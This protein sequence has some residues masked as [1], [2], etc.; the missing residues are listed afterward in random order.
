MSDYIKKRARQAKAPIFKE[1]YQQKIRNNNHIVYGLAH[2]TIYHRIYKK[3]EQWPDTNKTIREFNEWGQPLVIDLTFVKN[4]T[5][6]QAKSLFYRE[7]PYG[8]KYNFLSPEP[9]A[10]YLNKGK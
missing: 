8:L 5:Y 9:F 6:Q 2:N 4:M 7:L 10:I 1:A 3:Q